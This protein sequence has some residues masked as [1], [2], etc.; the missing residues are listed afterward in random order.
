MAP[1]RPPRR[2]AASGKPNAVIIDTNIILVA[3]GQN[4]DANFDAIDRCS[5]EL[6]AVQKGRHGLLLLDD[7]PDSPDASWILTE[8][9]N[10]SQPWSGQFPG[11]LFV[12]WILENQ[13]NDAV[14]LS[15]PITPQ[16]DERKT[17]GEPVD[18]EEFPRDPALQNFD[19]S[20]RK[21]VAVACGYQILEPDKSAVI[22][23]A[24]DSDFRIARPALKKAGVQLRFLCP[25]SIKRKGDASRA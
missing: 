24:S 7:A 19:L 15:I 1:P 13:F 22:V 5:R 3:N 23:E 16:G 20:D 21:F 12:R 6:E 8:Y 11:D 14:I 25:N 10:K 2:R 9:Q 17:S 18:Y 4:E